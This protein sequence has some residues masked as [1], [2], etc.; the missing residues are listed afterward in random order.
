MNLIDLIF[1]TYT[2]VETLFLLLSG[3][4]GRHTV[5][6]D[7]LLH[8]IAK[9]VNK[10]TFLTPNSIAFCIIVPWI[11]LLLTF[12]ESLAKVGIRAEV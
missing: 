7:D 3:I 12:G 4:T 8:L 2:L 1:I 6:P 10:E 9:T 5:T 11:V